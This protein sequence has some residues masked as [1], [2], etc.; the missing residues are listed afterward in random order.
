MPVIQ[1][2]NQKR[3]KRR[4]SGRPLRIIMEAPDSTQEETTGFDFNFDE[5][6][7]LA[8]AF[9]REKRCLIIWKIMGD[10]F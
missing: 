3:I 4:M 7:S 10:E 5:F 6:T 2:G 1:W 9:G 8:P